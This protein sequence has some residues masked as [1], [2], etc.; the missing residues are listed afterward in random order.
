MGRK[1]LGRGWQNVGGKDCRAGGVWT[2]CGGLFKS[3]AVVVFSSP[4]A[5]GGEPSCIGRKTID[6]FGLMTG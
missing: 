6:G 4:F 5:A 2:N 3:A 1:S